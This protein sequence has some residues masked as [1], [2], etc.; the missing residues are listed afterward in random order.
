MLPKKRY[1]HRFLT[2]DGFVSKHRRAEIFKSV[3]DSY[4]EDG[5]SW[6]EES[7][8]LVPA[9]A[10]IAIVVPILIL[11]IIPTIMMMMTWPDR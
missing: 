10:V 8:M 1:S 5:T 9:P 7:V 11:V 3:W 4:C 2:T 6:S